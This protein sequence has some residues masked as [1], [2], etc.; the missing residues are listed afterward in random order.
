MIAA[1]WLRLCHDRQRFEE[2]YGEGDF[3]K[4]VYSQDRSISLVWPDT[5]PC[6]DWLTPL[7]R[8]GGQQLGR[9]F[10]LYDLTSDRSVNF[11]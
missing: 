1:W 11:R 10:Q 2:K 5:Q 4:A 6:G 7:T 8:D 9:N 3:T